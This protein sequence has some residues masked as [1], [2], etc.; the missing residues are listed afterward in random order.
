MPQPPLT[1]YEKVN[2]VDEKGFLVNFSANSGA[3][4]SN[5]GVPVSEAAMPPGGQGSIGWISAIFQNLIS[6]LPLPRQLTAS[7]ST[8]SNAG[9]IASGASSISVANA[10]EASGFLNGETLPVGVSLEWNSS[11]N[12]TLSKVTYDATGT[13]FLIVEVR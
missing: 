1:P 6:R 3:G 9:A 13:T 12:N 8:V 5:D 10:G 2:I 7:Y 11:W 4:N